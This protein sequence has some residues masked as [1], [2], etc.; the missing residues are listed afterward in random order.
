[1]KNIVVTGA[2][3]TVGI[4]TLP[5]LLQED[6]TVRAITRSA[7]YLNMTDPKLTLVEADIARPETLQDTLQEA[8]ALFLTGGLLEMDTIQKGMIDAA[9]AQGVPFIVKLSAI[10]AAADSPVK[11]FQRHYAVEEHL[12]ASGIPYCLLQPNS[13][14]QNL[15]MYAPS[16]KEQGAIY[17]ALGEGKVSY[18]DVRDIARVAAVV[19]LSGPDQHH[20]QTYVLTGPE[21]KSMQQN[22][23]TIGEVI[24]KKITYHPI[25]YQESRQA[26]LGYGMQEW[27]ADDLVGLARLGAEGKASQVTTDAKEVTGK[28]PR[29]VQQTVEEYQDIFRQ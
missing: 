10:G 20:N 15:F 5:F 22:A 21:A 14:T 9:Q 28:A 2:T 17:A 4:S 19:L 8:D 23:E 7:D 3:G 11:M 24:G 25:S 13:F 18:I 16:I 1:M 29:S 12:K 26:M 6:V 27:L